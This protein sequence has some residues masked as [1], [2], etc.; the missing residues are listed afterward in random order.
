MALAHP[1][2]PGKRAVKRLWWCG[3]GVPSKPSLGACAST[4]KSAVKGQYDA[5]TVT[6][7]KMGMGCWY[8]IGL[9]VLYSVRKN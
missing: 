9:H 3:G 7:G 8:S 6:D 4:I 5:H 1:D 2:G